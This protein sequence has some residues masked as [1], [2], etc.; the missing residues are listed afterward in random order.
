[1]VDAVPGDARAQLGEF[2]GRISS[3]QH[4]EDALEDV[5]AQIGERRRAPHGG[6]EVVDLPGLQAG[7]GDD[8]LREH[9]ERV[10]RI[11][12]GLDLTVVHRP[13]DGG[14]GDEVAA[15][16]RKDD[17][18]A[19]GPGLVAGAADALQPAGHRGRRLDLDDQVDGA[20]VDAELERRGGDQSARMR[21]AFSR[22]STSLRAS[23]ASEP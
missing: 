5:A 13:G 1:M 19:D 4:V 14:A 15:E 8:L 23:R 12:R 9:V 20:H 22:S 10:S 17:P 18:F 3:R 6:E 11:A 7:H 21:P 16:L 2:V